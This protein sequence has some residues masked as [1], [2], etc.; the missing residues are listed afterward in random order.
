MQQK[1]RLLLV[2]LLFGCSCIPAYV[3]AAP[4]TG[5]GSGFIVVA[6]APAADF[7]TATQVGSSPFRVSFFDRSEGSLPR[8]YIW[9]FGDGITSREQNPTHIYTT[10][11]KYRNAHGHKLIWEGY[12]IPDRIYRYW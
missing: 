4:A 3:S 11:G 9:N 6:S 2:L 5:P 8:E 10:N 12:Q 1:L 7:Y